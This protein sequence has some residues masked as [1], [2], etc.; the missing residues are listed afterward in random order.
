M[1]KI[2]QAMIM[3][4]IIASPVIHARVCVVH[5]FD[6]RGYR[7]GDDLLLMPSRWVNEQ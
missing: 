6:T 4:A 3:A 1:K 7:K 5:D 2:V